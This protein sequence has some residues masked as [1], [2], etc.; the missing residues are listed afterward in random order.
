MKMTLI[1]SFLVNV[2]DKWKCHSVVVT[3]MEAIGMNKVDICTGCVEIVRKMIV[4]IVT[5]TMITVNMTVVTM[6]G[7]ITTTVIKTT[8][9]TIGIVSIG[10]MVTVTVTTEIM[11]TE[12]M[13]TTIVTIEIFH[14]ITAVA[15]C[16]AVVTVNE[17]MV[18]K[19]KE[20]GHMGEST[21]GKMHHLTALFHR[22]FLL[23]DLMLLSQPQR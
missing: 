1:D 20:L 11:S 8:A 21:L 4:N 19:M 16:P 12:S 2:K 7:E 15:V 14:E 23:A 18:V 6:I 3:T 5:V 22:C 9:M 13:T 10:N 17:T